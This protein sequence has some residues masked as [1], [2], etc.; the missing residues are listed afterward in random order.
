MSA[1]PWLC[2]TILIKEGSLGWVRIGDQPAF[3]Y[4][5]RRIL[6]CHTTKDR[7][8]QPWLRLYFEN[9]SPTH[10]IFTH[11]QFLSYLVLA[12][13]GWAFHD[14]TCHLQ[15]LSSHPFNIQQIFTMKEIVESLDW[16]YILR[17]TAPADT[18]SWSI[19]KE[20]H[21]WMD[22]SQWNMWSASLRV[23]MIEKQVPFSS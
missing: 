21:T 12:M 17:M 20:N 8:G 14:K 1:C 7:H 3:V 9:D 15:V 13:H 11:F 5:W 6:S 19:Y 2:Q 22:T 10:I 23:I 18:Q 16:G 4:I